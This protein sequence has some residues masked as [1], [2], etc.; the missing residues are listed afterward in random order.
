MDRALA[1]SRLKDQLRQDVG[2]LYRRDDREWSRPIVETLHHLRRSN[3]KA[4]FF[5]GTLR[6]LLLAR[7]QQGR[8]GRPRDLDIVVSGASL[9]EL[10]E[11]FQH[12]VRRETRFGG[13]QL[14]CMN[15]QFDI[16]PLEHTWAFQT[17]PELIPQF[18][19]L[20]LTTFFNL[21]AVAV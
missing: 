18:A 19:A 4:V 17:Q 9:D 7:L 21:E 1:I 20:P 15:W 6:A 11:R 12:S 14:E 16:W 10:R 3:V 2:A 13:L 5:G 8:F